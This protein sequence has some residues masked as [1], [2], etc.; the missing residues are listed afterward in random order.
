MNEGKI[1]HAKSQIRNALI[2]LSI[3]LPTMIIMLTIVAYCLFKLVKILWNYRNL[4]KQAS[5]NKEKVAS[6]VSTNNSNNNTVNMPD[7]M[8][9]NLDNEVYQN[10]QLA[11]QEHLNILD[12]QYSE[13]TK[14]IQTSF[15]QYEEYN[16]K[17]QQFYQAKGQDAPDKM[18]VTALNPS[19]DNY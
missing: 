19:Y 14:N 16:K 13:I 4:T 9:R 7:L 10:T 2:S 17:I 8:N 1:L 18:D 3:S 6:R 5:S 12:Q 15:K 11:E